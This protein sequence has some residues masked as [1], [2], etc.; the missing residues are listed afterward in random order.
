MVVDARDRRHRDG[1]GLV[2]R[3]DRPADATSV[4]VLVV[5]PVSIP[6]F[7]VGYAWHSLSPGFIG[8]RA[9]AVVMTLDLYPLV[10]LP[11]AAALRRTDPALEETARALGCGPWTTFRRVVLPQIR[12]A[13]LGGML[14]VTLALLAEFGAFEILASGRSPPR[15]SPSCRSTSRP[16][17]RWRCCWWRSGIV[18]LLGEALGSGPRRAGPLRR[19]RLAATGTPRLGPWPIPVLLGPGRAGRRGR[20]RAGRHA[21]LLAGHSQPRRCRP[22]PRCSPRRCTTA[23]YAAAAAVVATVAAVPVALLAAQRRGRLA[24]MLDGSTFLVQSV[25]GVVIALSLVFFAVRYAFSLYQTSALLVLAYALLFFPLALVCVRASALQASPRLAEM[26]RSLGYRPVMVFVRVTLPLIL[27]GLIAA[28]CLVFLSSVTELTATLVLVPTGVQTLAT[29]FWAYQT[30]TAYGAAAPYAAGDPAPRGGAEPAGGRVVRP[31]AASRRT[32]WWRRVMPGEP[33]LRVT[34]LAVS[35]GADRCCPTST[36]RCP[37]GR[38][39]RCSARRAAARPPCCGSSP[40]SSDRGAG[41][42]EVAGRVVDGPGAHVVPERRRLG[43]VPQE[44]ALFPHLTVAGNVGFGLR[45]ERQ[46]R[47]RVAELL[48]LVGLA[49]SAVGIRTSSPA[50]SSNGSRS[51]GRWPS[52][53]HSCCSTSRSRRSTRRCGSACA[54]TS[55]AS[56]VSRARRS[57]W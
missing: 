18:V 9:A 16:P 29:Q 23:R 3:T 34:G 53:P 40:A 11:V 43:Y 50:V 38:S 30:N 26:G 20:R 49:D 6:D 15:S 19:A 4:G 36:S 39:P 8:L 14:V 45:A 48:E 56:C 1:R 55:P 27:P 46:T 5:L 57:C 12:A 33:V 25:P 44:G 22:A 28:L 13:L 52:S 24:R 21:G 2:R 32:S 31:P 7:I 17:R 41:T 37:R 10:Y 47:A 42:I 54:P 35:F 51:P